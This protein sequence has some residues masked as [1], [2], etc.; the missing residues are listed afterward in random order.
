MNTPGA[1]ALREAA[2]LEAA[3]VYGRVVH[4]THAPISITAAVAEAELA[5]CD[6]VDTA[7]RRRISSQAT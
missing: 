4:E 5:A 7:V 6:E 1:E 2:R 3:R